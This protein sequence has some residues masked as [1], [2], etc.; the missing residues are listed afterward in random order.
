M[1]I[2]ELLVELG[3]KVSAL[4]AENVTLKATQIP[5]GNVKI[6]ITDVD[7]SKVSFT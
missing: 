6:L 4:E 1:T 5:S 2:A 3:N 7:M